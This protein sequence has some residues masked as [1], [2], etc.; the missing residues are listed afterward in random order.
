MIATAPDQ[1]S[2]PNLSMPYLTK[3]QDLMRDRVDRNICF[4]GI[5]GIF[6][7]HFRTSVDSSNAKRGTLTD[8]LRFFP[9]AFVDSRGMAACLERF[10][11][12]DKPALRQ[13]G[14]AVEQLVKGHRGAAPMSNFFTNYSQALS[15]QTF[16][17]VALLVPDLGVE[18]D[19]PI[20]RED[21]NMI[22]KSLKFALAY[23]ALHAGKNVLLEKPPAFT[24][25]ELEELATIAR[26]NGKTLFTAYHAAATIAADKL[27]KELT[28]ARDFGNNPID[29]IKIKYSEFVFDWHLPTSWVVAG[30]RGV[31]ADSGINAISAVQSLLAGLGGDWPQ[32]TDVKGTRIIPLGANCEFYAKLEFTYKQ[33]AHCNRAIAKG[34]IELDWANPNEHRMIE[35]ALQDK[36]I[37]CL[38]VKQS[39]SF[40]VLPDGTRK[41]V[42]RPPPDRVSDMHLEQYG[43]MY[44][45]F[46][47]RLNRQKDPVAHPQFL[48]VHTAPVVFVEAGLGQNVKAIR[49]NITVP[50]DRATLQ[51]ALGS[52]ESLFSNAFT[53]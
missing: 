35:I 51:S 20:A 47:A 16:G 49:S 14:A 38:D 13:A 10:G 34:S 7:D 46:A 3:L 22:G 4:V 32:F 1:G 36:R 40:I 8:D 15:D 24:E 52:N 2:N 12:G 23:Q 26:G 43:T 41:E 18:A 11:K 5:G 45:E 44:G 31:I 29:W 30:T 50:S 48:E 39:S 33:N 37:F 9:A 53:M 25:A 6:Y 19:S 42:Y 17:T 27:R 21:R 28:D